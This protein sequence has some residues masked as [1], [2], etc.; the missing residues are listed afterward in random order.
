MRRK[1]GLYSEIIITIALVVGA[2]LIFGGFLLL[3]LTE[4]EL[5]SQKVETSRHLVEFVA[6]A[7]TAAE[8][9]PDAPPNVSLIKTMMDNAGPALDFW[10][11]YDRYSNLIFSRKA[12]ET[13]A[14]E[15][16][17]SLIAEVLSFSRPAYTVNYHQNWIPFVSTEEGVVSVAAPLKGASGGSGVLLA[18]FSLSEVRRQIIAARNLVLLY[19]FLYGSV[20]IAFGVILLGRNVIEPVRR[21]REATS[22]VAAGDLTTNVPVAGP[23]E[24]ADLANSFNAMTDALQKGRDEI[25]R[26]ERMAS[27]GHLS[28]GMAHEIG[29]PLGAVLGY[30][31]L[32]KSELEPGRSLEMVEHSLVEISR[33]DHLVKELLDYAVPAG[34]ELGIV[35]PADVLREVILTLSHQAAFESIEFSVECPEKLGMVRIDSHKLMQVLVNLMVNAKDSMEDSIRIQVSASRQGQYAEI[36]VRDEGCGIPDDVL[37]HIFDPFY[38]SKPQG[39]GRGLGLTICQSIITEAGGKLVAR[40][41]KDAGTTFTIILPVERDELP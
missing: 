27:V 20:L 34:G 15:E 7:A 2:A 30:L 23:G 37:P 10:Q 32:L 26:S 9:A 39:K 1:S 14:V 29:N 40:S 3:R 16:E 4:R 41:R 28:A 22:Q 25:I 18:R 5:L 36:A 38:T 13:G 35:D 12:P 6:R 24:I 21:L 33:I 17:K 8:V 11:V 19:V 31:E